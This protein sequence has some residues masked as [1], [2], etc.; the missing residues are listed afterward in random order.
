[1]IEIYHGG[2]E[3][4]EVTGATSVE[5]N[6]T[7]FDDLLPG[8]AIVTSILVADA[9]TQFVTPAGWSLVGISRGIGG[10][11]L[12]VFFRRILGTETTQTF[13]WD[14]AQDALA[15]IDQFETSLFESCENGMSYGGVVTQATT[16]QTHD[17]ANIAPAW[18][19][20]GG[21]DSDA[22]YVIIGQVPGPYDNDSSTGGMLAPYE[23][24][25]ADLGLSMGMYHR[26]AGPDGTFDPGPLWW[27]SET[28]RVSVG[29]AIR[30]SCEATA[31]L[32]MLAEPML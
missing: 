4:F 16:G 30:C 24:N 22:I 3:P 25:T 23:W 32:G 21:S 7:V 14:I 20:S 31:Y 1:M 17:V 18:D 27:E 13:T 2:F 15:M 11:A 8:T 28:D 29:F 26:F 19:C 5:V 9:S 12:A 6:M 10:A